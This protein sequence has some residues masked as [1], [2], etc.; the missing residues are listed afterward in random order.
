MFTARLSF[1]L[2]CESNT[3]TCT[4][5]KP[6][7]LGM[8][9]QLDAAVLILTTDPDR[10]KDPL[11]PLRV[12]IHPDLPEGSVDRLALQIGHNADWQYSTYES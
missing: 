7:L 4:Y 3:T 8:P 9:G 2:S 10:S 6:E 5:Q 12:L 1:T 11:Q